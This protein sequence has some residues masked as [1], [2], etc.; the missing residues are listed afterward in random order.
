[1]GGSESDEVRVAAAE[2]RRIL[3]RYNNLTARVMTHAEVALMEGSPTG[4]AAA[5]AKICEAAEELARFTR[6]T[7]AD[8]LGDD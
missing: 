7:R 6:A 2:L 8:L 1:M 4:H 5:L 3:H